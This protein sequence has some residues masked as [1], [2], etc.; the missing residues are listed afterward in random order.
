MLL[1]NMFI[2]NW[3]FAPPTCPWCTATCSRGALKDSVAQFCLQPS[4]CILHLSQ[5]LKYLFS[6]SG[7]NNSLKK[8]LS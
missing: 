4:H 8:Q 1:F 3:S 6:K 2:G 5:C 7:A